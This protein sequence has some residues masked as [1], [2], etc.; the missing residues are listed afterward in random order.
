MCMRR[1]CTAVSAFAFLAVALLG[2]S[3]MSPALPQ[4]NVYVAF[5][6]DARKEKWSTLRR[7]YPVS[8]LFGQH[9]KRVR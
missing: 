7:V 4:E 8:E 2:V 9:L 1:K 6:D 3:Y 5:L